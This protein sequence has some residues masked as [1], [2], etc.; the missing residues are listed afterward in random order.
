LAWRRLYSEF[1]GPLTASIKAHLRPERLDPSLIDEISA[2]VWYLLVQNNFELL[3]RFDVNRGCRLTT[4]LSMLARTQLRI[5]F[6]SEKR[7]RV[8]ERE[9][10]RPEIVSPLEAIPC[11]GNLSEQEFVSTLTSAERAFYE[12]VLVSH[13]NSS[14]ATYGAPETSQLRHRIKKKLTNFLQSGDKSA[15]RRRK[16]L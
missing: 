7:R 8:R 13:E 5:F 2:R 10:Y 6:R 4:F 14:G 11:E 1:Q 9:A 3:D 15:I 12:Q 16:A